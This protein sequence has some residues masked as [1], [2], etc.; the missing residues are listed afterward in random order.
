MLRKF[1]FFLLLLG[2][3]VSVSAQLSS[4]IP[5]PTHKVSFYY[6]LPD[7]IPYE[8]EVHQHL[9]EVTAEI[10]AW[11]QIATGGLTFEIGSA[12]T[13]DLVNLDNGWQYYDTTGSW[14]GSL[15]T[16]L[17]GK[18]YPV[19]E[20][21]NIILCYARGAG[22][23]AGAA[24]SCGGDCGFGIIG[25]ELFAEFEDTT[26]TEGES[27]PGGS[28]VGAWP[29]TPVG[30]AAHELGHP[31][32]L[33]HPID[34]PNTNAVAFHSIMQTHWNYPD[35]AP[36]SQSPW[37]LLTVERTSL[38]S[39]PFFYQDIDLYQK[40]TQADVVNLPVTGPV[41]EADFQY[42]INGNTISLTNNSS[43]G[44]LYYW[45]FGDG[46]VSNDISPTHTYD[47]PGTYQLS[48]RV[49]NDESM[50]ALKEM[51]VT[52]SEGL[53]I[54]G[55]MLV[56]A[57]M[58]QDIM[59][60]HNGDVIFI[61]QLPTDELSIRAIT[62]PPIVGSVRFEWDGNTNQRVE[63]IAPY[64][65]HGDYNGDY[66][67]FPLGVGTHEIH[68]FPYSDPNA[69]GDIGSA[70]GLIFKVYDTNQAVTG[71]SIYNADTDQLIGPLENGAIVDIGEIGT[72]NLNIV[73]HTS[74]SVVGSVRFGLNA[75]ENFRL[76]NVSPYA[77]AGDNS[78][79][80]FYGYLFE[81]GSY[82]LRATPYSLGFGHGGTGID[83]LISF[84]VVNN[85][86][87]K[88]AVGIINNLRIIPNPTSGKVLL[89][90]KE[91]MEGKVSIEVL[92]MWGER[93]FTR[94]LENRNI[95]W[96]QRLDLRSL[97]SG[98]YL[99]KVI[100]NEQ[101]IVKRIVKQ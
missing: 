71:F 95:G 84:E 54:M 48:L 36:L 50:M 86:Y 25:I 44:T 9:K 57:E 17:L 64:S 27:C 11:Y 62:N 78:R 81:S 18:A 96:T 75:N 87:R 21:G 28:G 70:L 23:W 99:V 51:S 14:W 88:S 89:E 76:E 24:P 67:P 22:W 37:G 42:A 53:S 10:Q 13:V 94:E 31:F 8:A 19:W 6:V 68:V 34:F 52:I 79:G 33:P 69:S 46:H 58:D 55:L 92:S 38:R 32:G 39:N 66:T 80:D 97:P 56:D 101:W 41:P 4:L 40:F 12:D 29:C 65:I 90:M 82:S 74:P 15:Q 63:N 77:L 30:A 45:T 35:Y 26:Y 83:H 98:V 5:S 20:P 61:D 91:A 72:A 47:M 43:G 16:E 93:V 3:V 73:A 1:T 2:L 100:Q 7:D 59:P 60:I 85:S 49:S